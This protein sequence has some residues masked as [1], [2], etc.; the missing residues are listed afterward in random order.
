MV[1]EISFLNFD[2]SYML[3]INLLFILR[4]YTTNENDLIRALPIKVI[5]F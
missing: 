1:S 2:P 5:N 4:P 3:M